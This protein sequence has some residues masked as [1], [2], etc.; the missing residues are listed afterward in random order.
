MGG[1]GA[2]AKASRD[3][4]T[5]RTRNWGSTA[6]STGTPAPRTSE[7][8]TSHVCFGA[9]GSCLS[10]TCGCFLIVLTFYSGAPGCRFGF[11][12]AANLV[13][14]VQL[15][16]SGCCFGVHGCRF[17]IP[18]ACLV[19]MP[20]DHILKTFGMISGYCSG[21]WA[22]RARCL[23]CCSSAG[24][25]CFDVAGLVSLFFFLPFLPCSRPLGAFV[26]E[27]LAFFGLLRGCVSLGL[28]CLSWLSTSLCCVVIFCCNILFDSRSENA[29]RVSP[30]VTRLT[31]YRRLEVS[32]ASRS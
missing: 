27:L 16:W 32:P 7:K 9:L 19:F 3:H 15:C 11:P 29:L 10:T 12:V 23:G 6:S 13:Y 21:C 2:A 17:V 26:A 30:A 1:R 28:A 22:G 4:R 24:S 31:V 18:S 25:N 14:W 5:G 20:S 8:R